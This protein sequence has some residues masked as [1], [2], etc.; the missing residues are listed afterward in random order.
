MTA[1]DH[2]VCVFSES[3]DVGLA[4]LPPARKIAAAISGQVVFVSVQANELDA[5]DPILHGA[6][7]VL[8][9]QGPHLTEGRPEALAHALWAAVRQERPAVVLIGA[10]GNGSEIAARVAQRLGVACASECLDVG[11]ADGELVV[12]RAWLGG[13]LARQVVL[14]RPAIV[15]VPPGKHD[16]PPRDDRRSGAVE[17]LA[18]EIPEP[19]ARLVATRERLRSGV[20]LDKAH[21]IVAAGRGLRDKQDLSLVSELAEVLGGAVGATRPLTDDLEW[22]PVDLKVGL[23][24]QAVRPKLYIACGVSG[25]IEHVVGMRESQLVIA[26]NRDPNA[27]I[28]QEADYRVVGDLYEIVPA[29]TRVLK[30]VRTH[31][32]KAASDGP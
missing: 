15:T 13:F 27:L 8:V 25:Q 11:M 17:T 2:V 7:R 9:V 24:G 14:T 10:T 4:L 6:D 12:Q 5:R 21:I 29:L 22:L 19:G 30:E 23:S 20:R 32:A 26:I 16:I 18:V 31:G 1:G 28:M 3:P